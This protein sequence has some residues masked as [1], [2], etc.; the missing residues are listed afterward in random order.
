[1]MIIRPIATIAPMGIQR[2]EDGF[3]AT[4]VRGVAGRI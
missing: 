4:G 3:V 2:R 1:M